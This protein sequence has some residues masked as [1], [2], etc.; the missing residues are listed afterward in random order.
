MNA[1]A[2]P[3]QILGRLADE[4]RLQVL[5]AVALGDRTVP[6]IA[7]RTGLTPDEAARSLGRLL[8]TDIVTSADEG[9]QVDLHAFAAAARAASA[10]RMPPALGDATPEQALVLRNFVDADGRMGALPAREAKRRIVLEW[11]AT[12]FEGGRDYPEPEVNDVLVDVHDDY[13]ALRRLLVDEGFLAREAG[14]Y[15]RVAN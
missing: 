10:P 9:L 8:A 6:A 13:A 5:A 1:T 7:E 15:R 14:V 11:L 2:T 3:S 12:R 4:R